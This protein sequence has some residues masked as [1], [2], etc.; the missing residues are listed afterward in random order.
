MQTGPWGKSGAA[1]AECEDW[2]RVA[3]D[4]K[5]QKITKLAANTAESCNMVVREGEEVA[6]VGLRLENQRFST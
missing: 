5:D 1:L 2:R 4:D 6:L 3:Q